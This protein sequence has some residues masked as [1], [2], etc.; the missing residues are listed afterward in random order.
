MFNI[1]FRYFFDSSLQFMFDSPRFF[2]LV[3]ISIIYD[4]LTLI[5]VFRIW[6]VKIDLLFKC[7]ILVA[8]A[9]WAPLG[10][11]LYRWVRW[12]YGVKNVRSGKMKTRVEIKSK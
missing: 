12:K 7:F 10:Y 9:F 3:M 6:N 1:P 2:I 11:G 4:I 8:T 5:V